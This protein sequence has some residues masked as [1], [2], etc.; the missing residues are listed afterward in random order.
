MLRCGPSGSRLRFLRHEARTARGERCILVTDLLVAELGERTLVVVR[1][2]LDE[3][4]RV[5]LAEDAR[6]DGR[7]CALRV[8]RDER[9]HGLLVLALERLEPDEL[10]VA[11][12]R[13]GTVLVE[14]VGD[15]A[16]HACREIPPGRPE[17]DYA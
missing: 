16:A 6:R 5:P 3:P 11:A 4:R 10:R 2:H 15:A 14:D 8:L 17:H 12:R 13:E 9:A 1:H 7:A